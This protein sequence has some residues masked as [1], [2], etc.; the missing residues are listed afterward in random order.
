MLSCP[1]LG[2]MNALKRWSKYFFFLF[3]S[4]FILHSFIFLW[5]MVSPAPSQ[6]LI[7]ST[8]SKSHLTLRL[9]FFLRLTTSHWILFWLFLG[10]LETFH[11]SDSLMC[12]MI[13]QAAFQQSQRVESYKSH[14]VLQF[15]DHFECL[16]S[17]CLN[18]SPLNCRGRCN[19]LS[20]QPLQWCS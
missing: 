20:F 14:I 11:P 13:F 1:S 8:R 4:F 7:T 18:T 17:S 12:E 2:N 19:G 6:C 16:P 5:T 3:F 15:I 9:I 10:M